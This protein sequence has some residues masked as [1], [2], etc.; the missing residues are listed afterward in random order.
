MKKTKAAL[1]CLTVVFAMLTAGCQSA[2]GG[3]N[4]GNANNNHNNIESEKPEMDLSKET[5][6]TASKENVKLL[7]RTYFDE[8][9][10][11]CALSGTGAEFG[12]TG[13]QCSL[14]VKGD[15][16]SSNAG[17]KDNHARIGIYLD[18]ERV[19]DD[20]IDE[21]E[22]TYEVFKSEEPR[23]VTVSV[24]KLSE[25]PMSTVG[26]KEIK[27]VGGPIKPTE[28][29]DMLIE[30]VGDSI[31]CGYGVDDPD[32]DHHFVTA[33]EDVTKAYAYLTAK[34]L[35]ADYSMVSFSGYGII[36]GYT[37]NGNKVTAQTVPQYYTKLGYS[38]GT[39]GN[40][41]PQETDWDFSAKPD[42]V[43]VN[44]GTNDDSYTQND[45]DKQ[46]EY[47]EKY[48]EFLKL[49]RE[50]NP[51]ARIL[52]ILGVMGDRLYPFVEKAVD[53]FVQQTGDDN[54]SSFKLTPQ[55]ARDGYSADWHPSLKT[56]ERTAE[57]VAEEI[58]RL[59]K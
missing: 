34:A 6:Y 38:W 13:T 48:T 37:D 7:G 14:T 22:K 43:V 28:N 21:S 10:L 51:D 12:F 36:S 33:T 40:F 32:K 19:V 56:H 17:A 1:L 25:S 16:N 26:I 44:L 24:V 52:C 23:N 4:D 49:I 58:R 8:D 50:K 31:T 55:S 3:G 9:I 46:A 57:K 53:D 54:I 15:S 47:S 35:D 29:K 30:F 2:A 41:S 11:Y 5:V 42:L 20:M 18:G 45:A 27:C 39:N 59:M